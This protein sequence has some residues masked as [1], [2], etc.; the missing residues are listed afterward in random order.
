MGDGNRETGLVVIVE[1]DVCRT[2]ALAMGDERRVRRR[3]VSELRTAIVDGGSG[4]GERAAGNNYTK[5]LFP[6]S[7]PC[8]FSL[9]Q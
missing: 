3:R 6:S 5:S 9:T 2:E 1:C 7:R 4:Q 8:L